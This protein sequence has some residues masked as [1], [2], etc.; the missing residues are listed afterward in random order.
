MNGKRLIFSFNKT[1]KKFDFWMWFFHVFLGFRVF[2]QTD[3]IW[4][5]V[6]PKFFRNRPNNNQLRVNIPLSL[7]I[8][9]KKKKH[10]KP[11]KSHFSWFHSVEWIIFKKT[12]FSFNII[13][14]MDLYSDLYSLSNT[15][16]HHIWKSLI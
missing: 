14:K 5:C 2:H 15:H 3:K 16:Q 10:R 7:I 4:V 1:F 12:Y 8:C 6:F 11:P 9:V 13:S